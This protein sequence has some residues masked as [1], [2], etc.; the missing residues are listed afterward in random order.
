MQRALGP[1]VVLAAGVCLSCSNDLQQRRA[2]EE[3]GRYLELTEGLRLGH[4]VKTTAVGTDR[5]GYTQVRV[6]Q[7]HAGIPILGGE[8]IVHIDPRGSVTAMTDSLAGSPEVSPIPTLGASTAI[9]SALSHYPCKGCLTAPPTARLIYLPWHGRIPLVWEVHMDRDDGSRE[10]SQPVF[11]VDA[12]SG[13]VLYAY[14]N[15]KTVEAT[16]RSLYQGW[17]PL[18]TSYIED[19]DVYVLEDLTRAIGT[20]DADNRERGARRMVNEDTKWEDESIRAGVDASWA[21]R[22]TL[23]YFEQKHG[24]VGLDGNGGPYFYDA[25]TGTS[26]LITQKVHYGE[27]YTNAFW[28]GAY[29]GFGDGDGTYFG[30]MVSLDLVAHELTHGVVGSTADLLYY[31]EAGALNESVSDAFAALVENWSQAG[32]PNRIGEDCFTPSISGDALRYL[33]QPHAAYDMGL[34]DDDDPDHYLERY[35]GEADNEGVHVNAGIPNKAFHLATAGG[36]HHVSGRMDGLGSE[37]TSD[38]WFRAVTRYM[39]SDADFA[40]ARDTTVL[41]ATL[42]YGAD[43]PEAHQIETA[44]CMV[45]VGPCPTGDC[46]TEAVADGSFENDGEGWSLSENATLVAHDEAP[47]GA[48]ILLLTDD[49]SAWRTVTVPSGCEAR[50]NVWHR[51]DGEVVWR[52]RSESGEMTELGQITPLESGWAE[53]TF[54]LADWSGQT[55]RLGVFGEAEGTVGVDAVSIR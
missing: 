4:D 50:L 23:D 11:Y 1:V 55:I 18:E 13:E 17:L 29:A 15:L 52:I 14:D 31:G 53:A 5:L 9:D 35:E 40:Q 36:T 20:F 21:A 49:A 12:H 45:G 6:Q 19:E 24:H 10:V 8:A 47:D 28:N 26:G 44:W 42:E 38:V 7:T 43:S 27:D 39:T 54:D 37:I 16:G 30:P 32:N 3:A 2:T 25:A 34:T 41:A 22:T 46:G 51:G 33:S 48:R